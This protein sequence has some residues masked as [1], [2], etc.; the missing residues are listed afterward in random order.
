MRRASV[1]WALV[2]IAIG[3]LLLLGNLGVFDL[4]LAQLGLTGVSMWGLVGPLLLILIGLWFLWGM[5]F[6]RPPRGTEEVTIP[7]AGATQAHIRIRHGAGRL[8]IGAAESSEALLSGTFGGGL[9][10][11]T[12]RDGDRLDV[13]MRVPTDSLVSLTLPWAWG[14]HSPR[15]WSFD[16]HT[17]IPLSLDLETGASESRLELSDLHVTDLRLQTG[18]SA[19]ELTLPAHAGHSRVK[20]GAGAASVRVRVPDGV[21]AQIAVDSGLAGIS[22]NRQRFPREGRG[23]RSPDYDTAT[24]RV[25]IDIEAGVGS[26][27]VR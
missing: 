8:R 11:H 15:D 6:G 25:D 13:T 4:I 1:F 22:I 26:V 10:H 14:P 21:A 7:L 3:L 27:E 9:D 24:H 16:L 2:L 19:T 20:I 5:L 23:Y 17:G 12:T 18:A